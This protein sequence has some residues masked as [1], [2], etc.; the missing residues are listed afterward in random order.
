MLKKILLMVLVLILNSNIFAEGEIE[1]LAE[2][3]EEK[4]VCRAFVL[5]DTKGIR[6]LKRR[7]KKRPTSPGV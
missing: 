3:A 4:P 7:G 1:V 5:G 6:L 2:T